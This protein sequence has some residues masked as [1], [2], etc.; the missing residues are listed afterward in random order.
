MEARKER[1]RER[2]ERAKVWAE[3]KER[4]R[5]ETERA[6]GKPKK[7]K[8]SSKLG[9]KRQRAASSD[10]EDVDFQFEGRKLPPRMMEMANESHRHE[11]LSKDASSI[12]AF[13]MMAQKYS[14]L[15]Y[16]MGELPVSHSFQNIFFVI[17]IISRKEGACRT[18]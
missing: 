7:G 12:V 2:E 18:L 8:K 17:L 13:T 14:S 11:V 9:W 4:K 10:E 3:E 5:N 16:R 6:V 1:E 15:L